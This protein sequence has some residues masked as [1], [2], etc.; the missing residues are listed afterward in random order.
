MGGS[1]K[2]D[3]DTNGDIKTN[4]SENAIK[5]LLI[6]RTFTK[7]RVMENNEKL[8]EMGISAPDVHDRNID[9]A[10]RIVDEYDFISTIGRQLTEEEKKAIVEALIGNRV[11][12]KKWK[13]LYFNITK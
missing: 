5:Q 3:R 10:L 4:I 7:E 9:Y 11:L 1:I 13:R 6:A 8:K 2:Y 12:N